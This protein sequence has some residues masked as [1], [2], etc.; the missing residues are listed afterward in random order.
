MYQCGYASLDNICT[1]LMMHTGI[2]IDIL[3]DL[4]SF[5]KE[6]S[7][8]SVYFLREKSVSGICDILN[9]IV[10]LMPEKCISDALELSAHA[11]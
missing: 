11:L 5:C 10:V 1:L 7:S 3:R 4:T 8:A 9:E 6:I 2:G